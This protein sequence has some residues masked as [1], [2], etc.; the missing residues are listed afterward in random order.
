M[1]YMHPKRGWLYLLVVILLLLITLIVVP[2][3]V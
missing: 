1:A 2:G 3:T